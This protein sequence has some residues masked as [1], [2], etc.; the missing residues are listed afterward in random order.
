MN[1]NPVLL[2][3]YSTINNKNSNANNKAN[4][5]LMNVGNCGSVSKPTEFLFTTSSPFSKLCEVTQCLLARRI[6]EVFMNPVK[7]Q[8]RFH[9]L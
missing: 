4:A 1:A 3:L 2:E 7:Y 8:E 6:I 5:I 9:V